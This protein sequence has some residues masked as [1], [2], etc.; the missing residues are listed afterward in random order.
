ML[1]PVCSCC[2]ESRT[3]LVK[4]GSY[5]ITLF[6]VVFGITTFVGFDSSF[7]GAGFSKGLIIG[8]TSWWEGAV[9]EVF[10]TGSACFTGADL[11]S[12]C[13]LAGSAFA[14][15]AGFASFTGFFGTGA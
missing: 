13:F 9:T 3:D 14:T 11:G 6:V 4:S 7:L 1:G 8:F 2:G 5:L 12:A 15:G 10:F